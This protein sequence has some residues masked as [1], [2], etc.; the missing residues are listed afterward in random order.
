MSREIDPDNLSADDVEYVRVRPM[1]RQEFIMQ[2]YGDPLDPEYPGLNFDAEG[3]EDEDEE[4]DDNEEEGDEDPD[5]EPDYSEWEYADLKEAVKDR[6]LEPESKKAEDLIAALVA[7][8]E[9]K[10]E[11]D[12]EE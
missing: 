12:T 8:D 5:E 9:A 2:G 4:G 7:D 1:L 3:D 10:S 6:G 11:G